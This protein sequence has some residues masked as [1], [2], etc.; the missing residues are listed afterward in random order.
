MNTLKL[1]SD[2]KDMRRQAY[3]PHR[4]DHGDRGT[5]RTPRD[6]WGMRPFDARERDL[7]RIAA[8]EALEHMNPKQLE[9]VATTMLRGAGAEEP[10]ELE[11]YHDDSGTARFSADK[12]PRY[13]YGGMEE[14]GFVNADDNAV[15]SS[16]SRE[17]ETELTGALNG[18]RQ[19]RSDAIRMYEGVSDADYAEFVDGFT[20]TDR[21]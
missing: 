15:H 2:P 20:I 13:L 11:A 14:P 5:M 17:L 3:I 4:Q 10:Q 12:S 18:G 16:Y 19:A 9:A 8:D 7:D 6:E 1:T 21:P